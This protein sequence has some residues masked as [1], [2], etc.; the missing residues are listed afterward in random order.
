VTVASNGHSDNTGN[1]TVVAK[2]VTGIAVK[3]QPTNLY[4]IE[5]QNLDL[6][7]LVVTLTYNDAST[8][9]VALVN[10]VA[11]GIT[12][13]PVNGTGLTVAAHHNTPVTVS[14][15]GK[16]ATTSNLTVSAVAVDGIAIKTQPDKLT[17]I[18]GNMLDLSGLEVT[19][20]FND[21]STL[22]VAFADFGTNG[23]TTDP[24][25]GIDL[26][27]AHHGTPV[28]VSCNGKT[29]T[30]DNLTVMAIGIL[31][32]GINVPAP[33]AAVV[34]VLGRQTRAGIEDFDVDVI[35]DPAH[36][37]FQY[38]TVYTAIII[39]TADP[40][41]SF[42]GYDDL[43]SIAGFT[44]NGSV[45]TEW[46]SNNGKVLVF[47]VT[48][49]QTEARVRVPVFDGLAD[50]YSLSGFP[51]SG[52]GILLKVKVPVTLDGAPVVFSVQGVT[53]TTGLFAPEAP[54]VY[55]IEANW[56]DGVRIWKYV[57]VNQ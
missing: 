39:L 17:Y 8:A 11:N 38:S 13:S 5:G 15:N 26:T 35:W 43:A 25:N 19:L 33:V 50:S 16:T 1:L 29:A 56:Y 36:D 10:F 41:F 46:V 14:C 52:G 40:G 20:T 48:F 23:I 18:N 7:G 47:K 31:P 34:P 3:T 21:A 6:S 22:D 12:T 57:T 24:V 49:P 37:P 53:L 55:L 27:M 32:S 51:L 28:T 4:Y 44:V 2:A 30:T 45:P 54:G 9:D 42:A